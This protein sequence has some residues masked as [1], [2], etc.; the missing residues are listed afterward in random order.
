[1]KRARIAAA[2]L[3]GGTL[4]ASGA[5]L[6]GAPGADG[7]TAAP[8][9]VVPG[10]RSISVSPSLVGSQRL[11]ATFQVTPQNFPSAGRL[12]LTIDGEPQ[13]YTATANGD[14]DFTSSPSCGAHTVTLSTRPAGAE[15]FSASAQT[16][17]LCPQITLT[18][19]TMKGASQ[20][21][22][23]LVTGTQF[24]ASQPVTIS[25]N[26]T[27]VGSTVTNS[28]GG[29]T[30]PI[31]ARG[32][33]CTAYQ[34][35]AS[36]QATSPGLAFLFSASAPLQATECKK[37]TLAINPAVLEPGELTQVTGTGFTPGAP[38]ML[39]WQGVS[40]GAPLLGTL[41]VT[42]TAG[43][44]IGGFFLVMPND[45]LGPRQ[46][47]ATQGAIKLTANAV[48]DPGPMEPS[49]GDRLINRG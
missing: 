25:L 45:P 42:V 35:T 43:G 40:G 32:L 37:M 31:I 38:V 41:S 27:Q 12:A 4:L 30:V 2:V 9:A 20:P 18:P 23:V 21:A 24:H 29:F 36:E 8:A 19:A 14:L 17:V 26:G 22:T 11:P 3:A 28:G 16:T 5:L 39:S 13:V 1:M 46:L 15:V 47:V 33:G 7:V 10:P 34:V 6:A 44:T 48:V 49:S